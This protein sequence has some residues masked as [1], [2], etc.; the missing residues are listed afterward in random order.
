MFAVLVGQS[1]SATVTAQESVPVADL[2]L[3]LAPPIVLADGTAKPI[4]YLQ[5]LDS[6]GAPRLAAETEQ[7]TLSSSNPAVAAVSPT[8]EI[9]AGRSYGVA[10]LTTTQTSG[11]AAITAR[12]IAGVLVTAEVETVRSVQPLHPMRLALAAAPGNLVAGAKPLGRLSITSL[13]ADGISI[14]APEN[15]EIVV[16]SSD[17]E[18]LRVDRQATLEQGSHFTVVNLEPLEPG[19][20]TLTAVHAGYVSEFIEVEVVEPDAEAEA[21]ALYL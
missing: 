20:V 4:V 1:G 3:I 8:L 2:S 12:S 15:L 5:L 16:N 18:V 21:L 13:D 11:R 10:T 6:D 7:F 19:K 14:P 9:A 17:P